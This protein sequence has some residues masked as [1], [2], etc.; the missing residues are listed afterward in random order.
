MDNYLNVTQVAA[1]LKLQASTVYKLINHADPEV[2]LT[3]INPTSY[4]GDG[5]YRFLQSDIEKLQPM[6]VKEKLTPTEAA[7]KI[8]RSITYIYQLI[9]KGLPHE[10][11]M[12]RGKE[13]YLI[14][15]EDLEPYTTGNY[16]MAK[17]DM[18][19]DK[20]S[21]T[22]LF[23]PY[24]LEDRVGRI[25][26]IKRISHN[27]VS[28]TLQVGSE[29]ISLEEALTKGAA[30]LSTLENK[31]IISSHGY[32]TF[33]FPFSKDMNSLQFDAIHFLFIEAGP[34]NI[35][36]RI[37]GENIYIEVKKIALQIPQP[38]IVA[39]LRR[40]L[41]KGEINTR[42]SRVLIDT[43]LS[44][45]TFYLKESKK[46][47][48]QELAQQSGLPLQAWLEEHFNQLLSEKGL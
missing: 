23:Q 27:Q 3:P 10:R 11:A 14:S 30:P 6:Y 31:K 44:P 43:G 8:G 41:V 26:G 47:S 1:M 28:T 2:K 45:I 4:R 42:D 9:K 17:Y 21:G 29:Q 24:K 7:K 16:G 38:E 19:H 22:Y 36:V 32:A 46:N 20:R 40:Y 37:S 48:L 18:I 35:R 15:P 25:I 13:T 39:L 12:Y 34:L 33:V 5:G